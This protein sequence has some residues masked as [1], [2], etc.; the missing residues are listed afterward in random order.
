MF[1][2]QQKL[3]CGLEVFFSL[4]LSS[5]S[6][7]NLLCL[8]SVVCN[9]L[10]HREK[11]LYHFM[12]WWNEWSSSIKVTSVYKIFFWDPKKLILCFHSLN[13]SEHQVRIWSYLCSDISVRKVTRWISK[14]ALFS[15]ASPLPLLSHCSPSSLWGS[16]LFRFAPLQGIP[17]GW[18]TENTSYC[19]TQTG[20]EAN[21]NSGDTHTH[22]YRQQQ[23]YT[24]TWSG[25]REF[26]SVILWVMKWCGGDGCGFWKV[27]VII[28]QGVLRSPAVATTMSSAHLI[29]ETSQG[30]RQTIKTT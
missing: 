7:I 5:Y 25:C 4:S 9:E 15:S 22:T 29:L 27:E 23:T 13:K 12:P 8:L 19:T 24:R 2:L 16:C 6:L 26:A 1:T 20:L 10:K 30:G 21:S 28:F 18:L 3:K 14:E 17:R 11:Q